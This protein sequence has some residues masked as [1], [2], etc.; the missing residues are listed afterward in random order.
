M[1]EA[2]GTGFVVYEDAIPIAR[3]TKII[4]EALDCDPLKLISSGTLIASI[5]GNYEKLITTLK[6]LG[7]KAAII[8]EVVHKKE[9]KKLVRSGGTVESIKSAVTDE[10]WRILSEYSSSKI[11]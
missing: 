1:A 10:L 11:V 2:S 6:R 7:I 4:C 3:E 5:R 8:G 9:G